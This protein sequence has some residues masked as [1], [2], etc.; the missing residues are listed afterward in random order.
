M[1]F[2]SCQ[3]VIAKNISTLGSE[4]V[5][6]ETA[7]S[8]VTASVHQAIVPQPEFRQSLRDGYVIGDA[9]TAAGTSVTLPVSG[10]IQA[11]RIAPPSLRPGT[12]ARIM[13]GGMVPE[14]GR[15]VIPQEDCLETADTIEIPVAVLRQTNAFIQEQGCEVAAGVEVVSAGTLL[16]PDHISTLAAVGCEEIEVYNRP[17]VG[18]L[19][20]GSELVD[21]PQELHPGLKVSSNRYLLDGLI[22]QFGAE[23]AYLGTVHDSADKLAAVIDQLSSE[24][25]D[26][27]ISTGGMG[28][29]KY[30]LIEQAFVSTGGNVL[31][32]S[33]AM[34]PGKATLCGTL[35]RTLFF[36]LPGPP[37]AVRAL[38]NSIVGPALLRMQGVASH[39]P[40]TLQAHL[41]HELVIKRPGVMQLKGATLSV[42]SSRWEVHEASKLQPPSCYLVIPADRAGYDRGELIDIHLA[43][44]PFCPAIGQW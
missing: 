17:R 31:Y 33:L 7:L 14:G 30:D 8:R 34:R 44:S 27:V 15:R 41:A 1:D 26:L 37:T 42:N 36:G 3:Q 9:D 19:C 12:A 21:T 10:M 24:R 39:Y 40:V 4:R 20:T 2:Q 25:Y 11:G 5:S 23:P 28:P 16:L 29:G 38:M 6:L 35:G 18:Y 13:T 43:S 32:N 22:R